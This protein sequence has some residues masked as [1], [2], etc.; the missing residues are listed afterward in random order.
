M[1]HEATAPVEATGSEMHSVK[2]GDHVTRP[3]LS[4]VGACM[5]CQEGSPG[6]LSQRRVL[7]FDGASQMSERTSRR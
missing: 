1:S 7:C 6:L 3:A 4:S 5:C 2:P